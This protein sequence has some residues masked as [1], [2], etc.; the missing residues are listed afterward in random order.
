MSFQNITP[1]QLKERLAQ[2][3]ELALVDVRMPNEFRSV[4]VVGA[5]NLPLDQLSA[6][7][8][9]ATVPEGEPQPVY[10]VCKGGVRSEKACQKA[11]SLGWSNIVNVEGGTDACIAAGLTVERGKKAVSLERQVR[12]VAGT[13]ALVGGILAITHH[14]YWAGLPAFVGAGLVFSGVT[15]TCAMATVLAKM[16]WNR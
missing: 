14:V 16:P 2:Q 4:H 12:I 10:F 5:K 15:D 7:R 3:P 13:M 9:A 1:D 6:D 8:L 11:L